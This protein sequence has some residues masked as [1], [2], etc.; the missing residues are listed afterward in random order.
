M[1]HILDCYAVWPKINQPY[2]WSDSAGPKGRTIPASD[3][4]GSNTHYE[5]GINLK[6]KQLKEL[7][8]AVRQAWKNAIETGKVTKD[9]AD[10]CNDPKAFMNIEKQADKTYNVKCK[11][12]NYDKDCKPLQ[13]AADKQPL[14]ED[15][16][17]TNESH[18]HIAVN[19]YFYQ[20]G[21]G[22]H[23]QPKKLR[24]VQLAPRKMIDDFEAEAAPIDPD[25]DDFDAPQETVTFGEQQAT[26]GGNAS[27]DFDDEIPF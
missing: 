4:T 27:Q 8:E 6:E 1:H 21:K 10:K 5:L 24:V 22:L 12:M 11:I 18:I 3:P 14:P 20:K 23:I 16:E 2:V 9:N 17:L 7:I 19:F 26:V 13:F 25:A 15:F